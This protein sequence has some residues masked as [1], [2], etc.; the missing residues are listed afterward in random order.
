MRKKNEQPRE[1]LGTSRFLVNRYDTTGTLV[2]SPASSI[3]EPPFLPVGIL[4]YRL[5]HCSYSWLLTPVGGWV[6]R[7]RPHLLSPLSAV[8]SISALTG[9]GLPSNNGQSPTILPWGPLIWNS[10]P[11]SPTWYKRTVSL[12]SGGSR[13]GYS[14]HSSSRPVRGVHTPLVSYLKGQE[15]SLSIL[16]D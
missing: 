15:F 9:L 3:S 13:L 10:R 8:L 11:R 5:I 7:P 1:L 4:A 14:C 12:D 2:W 16:K 6:D